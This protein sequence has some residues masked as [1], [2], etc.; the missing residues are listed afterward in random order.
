MSG[1]AQSIVLAALIFGLAA[2][3]SL[4]AQTQASSPSAAPAAA[5][6]STALPLAP[7]GPENPFRRFEIVSLGTFPIMLFYSDFGFDL[8]RYSAHNFDSLYAPW[9][10][11]SPTSAPLTDSERYARIGVALGA[12]VIVGAID[13]YFHAMKVRKARRLHDA[14]E[15]AQP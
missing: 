14:L 1:R 15:S 8:Q 12:C 4:T 13:A 9:P 7:S 5:A 2:A 10:I 6:S 11:K 3:E